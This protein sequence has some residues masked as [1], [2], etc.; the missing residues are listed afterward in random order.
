MNVNP[1]ASNRKARSI[2]QRIKN[3]KI[4]QSAVE[5][6]PN[7]INSGNSGFI[8]NQLSQGL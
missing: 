7:L 2:N 1:P 3:P 6:M 5:M 4:Y 8:Q